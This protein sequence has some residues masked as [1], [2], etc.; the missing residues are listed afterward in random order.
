M[1]LVKP[2]GSIRK[3]LNL[4]EE[5]QDGAVKTHTHTPE[6]LAIC[7]QTKCTCVGQTTLVPSFVFILMVLVI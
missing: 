5:R 1:V 6:E 7:P 2:C 4:D 3:F